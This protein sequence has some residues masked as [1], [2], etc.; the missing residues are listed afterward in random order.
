MQKQRIVLI[1]AVVLGIIAAFMAKVYI[2]QQKHTVVEEAD[3]K[4]ADMQ[5]RIQEN[6][7]PVL[8]AKEEIIQGTAIA[9][10]MLGVAIIPNQYVEPQAVTSMDSVSGMI[11]VT[12]IA[13]GEQI[14]LNKLAQSGQ[15]TGADLA[16][17][18]P[19]GKRAVTI[20]IDNIATLAGMVK[21]GDFVDVISLVSVPMPAQGSARP[22][23][24][25][26]AISLFQN[27]LV[28]AVG[29]QTGVL[30]AAEE[31]A[32]KTAGGGQSE[33]SPL[34]TLALTSQEANLI[35]F[36]QEQGKIRLIMRSPED[37]QIQQTI[38]AGWDNLV[39]YIIPKVQKP[40]EEEAEKGPYVEVYR[41]LNKD[42]VF[43]SK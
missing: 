13:K 34:V 37:T 26:S 21:P 4:I 7:T 2:D 9:P 38:P 10:N 11:T 31:A 17:I 33:S 20:S 12:P 32:R 30:S 36:V 15:R 41:G 1:V 42:K 14:T 43:L 23:T 18:T 24:Q 8:V 16:Q 29:Q 3:K 5:A 35:A 39:Q 40:V 22:E 6:Q 28:L 19:V 27:V 25:V